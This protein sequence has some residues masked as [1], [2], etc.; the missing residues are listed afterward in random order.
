M[1]VHLKASTTYHPETDRAS[2]QTNKT[3]IQALHYHVNSNQTDWV[4]TLPLICFSIMNMVNK[5]T[6]FTSFQ[7]HFGHGPCILPPLTHL[8][9]PAPLDANTD[10]SEE[11]ARQVAARIHFDFLEAQYNLLHAKISQAVHAN[12]SRLL[13]FPFQVGQ[14]VC[15]SM[16]NCCREFKTS[17]KRRVAKFIPRFSGPWKIIA[18]NVKNSTIT[19]DLPNSA[20]YSS[21]FHTSELIP[22]KENDDALFPGWACH[23]SNPVWID[24]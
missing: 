14:W 10:P 19:L 20:N 17:S 12:K 4:C 8:D 13:M 21:V 9:S 18:T 1:E 3:V 22:Y 24:D 7:L 16:E 11:T 23:K 5:S 6:G 15:L 2:E